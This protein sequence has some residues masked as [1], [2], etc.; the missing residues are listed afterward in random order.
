MKIQLK[1]FLVNYTLK[2]E[3]YFIVGKNKNLKNVSV[4][5]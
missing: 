1:K 4:A 2:F 3:Y 5:D